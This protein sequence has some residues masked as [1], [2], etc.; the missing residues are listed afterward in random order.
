MSLGAAVFRSLPFHTLQWKVPLRFCCFTIA[1]Y[2]AEE[3][4]NLVQILITANKISINLFGESPGFHLHSHPLC[5]PMAFIDKLF[6]SQP[7]DQQ[8][9]W[10]D[11]SIM[12]QVGRLMGLGR[13]KI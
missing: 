6:C 1:N 13:R 12:Q 3:S 7:T 4:L 9:L 10:S 2:F 5:R 11:C 8:S